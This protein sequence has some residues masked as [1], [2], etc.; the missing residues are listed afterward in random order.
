MP[1]VQHDLRGE[2]RAAQRNAVHGREPGARGAGEQDL[3]VA[4]GEAEAGGGGIAS[5]GG[6][7]ARGALPA[8]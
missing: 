3:A 8:E 1:G 4:W 5:G 6:E 2:Q 7:L